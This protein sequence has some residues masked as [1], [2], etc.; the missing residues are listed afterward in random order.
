[1]ESVCFSKN[2]A[3]FYHMPWHH[4]PVD[5]T[6]HSYCHEELKSRW[7]RTLPCMV[8]MKILIN[9]C[10]L[11]IQQ[12]ALSTQL[13]VVHFFLDE[14]LQVWSYSWPMT[15]HCLQIQGGFVC[16]L[17]FDWGHGSPQ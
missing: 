10:M 17:W 1:M 4:V 16:L 8:R 13:V 14:T 9:M 2:S 15:D 12:P 7:F 11:C 5:S 3:N 6:F